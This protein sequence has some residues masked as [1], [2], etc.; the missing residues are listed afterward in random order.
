MSREGTRLL[1]LRHS[2]VLYLLG[3]YFWAQEDL[4]LTRTMIMEL[5]DC[6]YDAYMNTHGGSASLDEL[7]R[8]IIV[9]I[10][11]GMNHVRRLG[12]CHRDLNP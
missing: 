9:Q 1:R 2:N 4:I 3:F 7:R 5:I 6:D 11:A 10:A 8:Y 12:Y